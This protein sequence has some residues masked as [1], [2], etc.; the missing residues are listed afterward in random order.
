MKPEP[1]VGQCCSNIKKVACKH[2]GKEYKV[3]E[4]WP[5][6]GDYCTTIECTE[7]TL[8]IQKQTTVATCDTKCELGWDYVP[9]TP[10]SKQCC[11][12]C[13]AVACVADG[14]I[15]NVGDQWTSP[16]FCTNFFCV[17]LEGSVSTVFAFNKKIISSISCNSDTSSVGASKLSRVA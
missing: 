1:V 8:G 12:S 9:A 2:N 7:S 4:A 15:H 17:N 14:V 10:D 16:D 11:G 5:V 13:K 6:E 3:G